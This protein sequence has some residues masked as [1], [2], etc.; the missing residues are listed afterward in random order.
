[1]DVIK[2]KIK[3]LEVQIETLHKKEN[4]TENDN[5]ELIDAC[6]EKGFLEFRLN[7][8]KGV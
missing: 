7:T 1:M 5:A 2:K 8:M 6:N 3:D 4:W